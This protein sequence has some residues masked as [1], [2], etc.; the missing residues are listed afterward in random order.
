MDRF[1]DGGLMIEESNEQE[2]SAFCDQCGLE[3]ATH[4]HSVEDGDPIAV[5]DLCCDLCC[6]C[7]TEAYRL[8]KASYRIETLG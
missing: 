2:A 4:V 1:E 8:S 6:D 7:C 5:C 3:K